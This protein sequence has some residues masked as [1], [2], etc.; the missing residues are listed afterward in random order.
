VKGTNAGDIRK[1]EERIPDR[2]KESVY[3]KG[4][5]ESNEKKK[6]E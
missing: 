4:Q 3:A 1:T 5:R 6:K 2:S